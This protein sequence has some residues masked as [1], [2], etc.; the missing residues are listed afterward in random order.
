[1]HVAAEASAVLLN[2][3]V[4]SKKNRKSF[5]DLYLDSRNQFLFDGG[6]AQQL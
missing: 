3:A 2:E 6:V 1:M 4:A 5:I